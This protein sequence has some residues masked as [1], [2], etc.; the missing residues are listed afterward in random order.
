MVNDICLEIKNA[1]AKFKEETGMRANKVY[2]PMDLHTDLSL[3]GLEIIV[4][5]SIDKIMVG[6]KTK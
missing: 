6:Y 2:I 3:K 1:L 5:K 4:D